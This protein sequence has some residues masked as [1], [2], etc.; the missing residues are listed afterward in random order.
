M[1]YRLVS[2]GASLMQFSYQ[3]YPPR[4]GTLGTSTRYST[5]AN[6]W[7]N[8]LTFFLDRHKVVCPTNTLLTKWHLYRPTTKPIAIEYW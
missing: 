4:Y 5:G 8:G 2:Q 1:F 6:D 3:C 7:S